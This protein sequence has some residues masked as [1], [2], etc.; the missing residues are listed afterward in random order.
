[1]MKRFLFAAS[2]TLGLVVGLSGQAWAANPHASCSGL[3]GS[4]RAGQP[5]AQAQVVFGVQGEAAAE[6]IPPGAIFSDFSR[7]H[8]GSAETCLS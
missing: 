8:D 7:H 2:T 3:A 1:M 6:G 4:S 5:G